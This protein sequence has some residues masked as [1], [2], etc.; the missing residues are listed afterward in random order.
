VLPDPLDQVHEVCRGLLEDPLAGLGT[1]LAS[2]PRDSVRGEL[3][4]VVDDGR[5]VDVLAPLFGVAADGF[6][7]VLRCEVE[8]DRRLVLAAVTSSSAAE[9]P[10]CPLTT[11]TA[12]GL[13]PATDSSTSRTYVRIVSGET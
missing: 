9:F 7:D 5:P 12:S 4:G 2:V 11:T 13:C 3:V 10:P 1:R 6:A 8:V